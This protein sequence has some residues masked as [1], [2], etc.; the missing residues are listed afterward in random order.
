MD[1]APES[2]RFAA[3]SGR[4]PRAGE[5]LRLAAACG[6][7]LFAMLPF[8][9]DGVMGG[10][11]ARWYASVVGDFILQWRMGHWPVFVGQTHFSPLGSV[12]PLRV[13]PYLQHL[14]LAIDFATGRSF[15]PYLL[16]NLA[17]VVSGTAGCLSAYL[18]LRSIL[19]ARRL[20]ALLLAVLY[21]WC[22]AVTGLAYAG[23]LFMSVVTLPFLPIVFT[24]VVRIFQRDSFSGWA[25]TA[26]GCAACWLAHTPIGLWVSISAAVA[27]C[28][29][30]IIGRGWSRTELARAVG[31]ALLFGVL[32]GYVFLSLRA[33]APPWSPP[34]TE[35]TLIPVVRT[36][37]PAVLQPVSL[38]A[39]QPTDLQPGW[40]LLAV[41]LAGTVAALV[42]R[43]GAAIALSIVSVLLLCLCLP[44]PV[45]FDWL[46]RVAVPQAVVTVTNAVPTQRLFPILAA[47]TV[48]L[49]ASALAACPGRRVWALAGLVAG[50]LWSG[51]ELR[52][53]H[54]RA[55]FLANSKA[56][57]EEMLS[58]DNFVPGSFS[59]GLLPEVNNFFSFGFMDFPL[60]QRVLAPDMRS[61]L[62]TDVNAVA[63]GF[64]F[65]SHSGRRQLSGVFQGKPAPDGR[66]WIDLSPGI[67][68][69]PGRR[70]LLVMD[71]PDDGFT[72]V[73]QLHG[74]GVNHEYMLPLSGRRFA[75]GAGPESS[76]AIPLA[77][78]SAVPVVLTLDFVIQDPKV[79]MARYGEFCRYELIPYDPEALP[80]RL[81][82]YVPYVAEVRS[83][84]P[85]WY[86]SFRYFSP[87][88][89]ATVNGRPAPVVQSWNGLVAVQ[90]GAGENEVRL[91]YRAPASLVAAYW[92]T[93]AAWLGLALVG[94]SSCRHR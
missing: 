10:E 66:R 1:P 15:S 94:A 49:A 63:P 67:T 12:M 58:Q 42:R 71:F 86:E 69:K 53:F 82:S 35:V 16:L 23:Q 89:T 25:M 75:F 70:Y 24:G 59:A 3:G 34:T 80:M 40:S 6:A 61:Y 78:D 54:H 87:G 14:T 57:S 43:S 88:W 41:L 36:M 27:L 19:P 72:G 91:S 50:L 81:K 60:E 84:A 48:V 29:R 73:I 26:A 90:V 55:R 32:C 93:G 30:W 76:R 64:D 46:W 68:L 47:C 85:G 28:C 45:V 8:L 62:A 39:G 20:E 21:V 13:A 79:D 11:D 37:F 22:P 74:E 33:L 2:R 56:T 4:S 83:P 51:F 44:V 77:N 65:G 5:A 92:L 7:G 38:G 17:I 52:L 31:A 9:R 18:C